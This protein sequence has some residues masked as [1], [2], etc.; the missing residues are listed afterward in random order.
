MPRH[1]HSIRFRP[2]RIRP[3][4]RTLI[5]SRLTLSSSLTFTPTP[6]PTITI[7]ITYTYN[8][9]LFTSPPLL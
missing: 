9:L 2:A 3:D 8:F 4:T 6:S 7:N 1:R 5:G